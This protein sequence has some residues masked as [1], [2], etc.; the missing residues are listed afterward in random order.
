MRGVL[1]AGERAGGA[2]G[3]GRGVPGGAGGD[4]GGDVEA[5]AGAADADAAA[6]AGGGALQVENI[7]HALISLSDNKLD[8]AVGNSLEAN[9]TFSLIST[10]AN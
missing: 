1:G 7:T 3:A 10:G 4:A 2:V 8:M 9:A 6:G 5:R